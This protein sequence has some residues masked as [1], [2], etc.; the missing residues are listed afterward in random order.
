MH[1]LRKA[2]NAAGRTPTL[3]SDFASAGGSLRRAGECRRGTAHRVPKAARTLPFINV[4]LLP[5]EWQQRRHAADKAHVARRWH[6]DGITTGQISPS[7]M[8]LLVPQK[9]RNGPA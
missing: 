7:I 4:P 8:R 1:A 9:S 3:H 2:R 6:P 5:I